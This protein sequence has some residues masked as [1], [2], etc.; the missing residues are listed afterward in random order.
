M[1]LTTHYLGFH[2]SNPL[3]V[4][5]SPVSHDLD[6]ARKCV[7]A[8]ASAIVMYSLF[9][10]QIVREQMSLSRALLDPSENYSEAVSYLPEPDQLSLGPDR[11]FDNIRKLKAQLSVPVIASLNGVTEGGWTKY[12]RQIEQAGADALELNTYNLVTDPRRTAEDVERDTLSLVRQIRGQIHIPLAVK[13][14]PFYTSLPNLSRRLVDAGANALVLF[15]RFYQPDIDPESL[16]VVRVNLSDSSELPLRLHWLAILYG[17]VAGASLSISGGVHTATD[18][19][20]SVMCGASSV[21]LVS[22]ILRSGPGCIRTTLD[23]LRRWLEEHE[24]ESLLQMRGSM[25]LLRCPNPAEYVRDN[26]MQVL[27]SWTSQ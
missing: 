3:I 11:Y 14:S 4:G 15:N 24:Y 13:L 26:Y 8:G 27:R 7:E 20:K 23:D 18:V 12:A 16:Q 19:V 9:E 6:R 17:H 2:L 22:S 1:D 5:A 25:S 10:E 21:Q